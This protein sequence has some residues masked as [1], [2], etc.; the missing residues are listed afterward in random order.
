MGVGI[1]MYGHQVYDINRECSE[2]IKG[3]G[4]I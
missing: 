4:G 1:Y 3:V 2:G